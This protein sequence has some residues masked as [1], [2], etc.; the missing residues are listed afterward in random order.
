MHYSLYTI[1]SFALGKV[2][3]LD[4]PWSFAASHSLIHF[5]NRC[6][7]QHYIIIITMTSFMHVSQKLVFHQ[8]SCISAIK[9]ILSTTTMYVSS[10]SFMYLCIPCYCD[11]CSKPSALRVGVKMLHNTTD[12]CSPQ[13]IYVDNL[14]LQAF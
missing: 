13:Q 7:S 1:S 10:S 14:A 4:Y 11:A 5:I 9:Y 12:L 6:T 2:H 8:S 3:S